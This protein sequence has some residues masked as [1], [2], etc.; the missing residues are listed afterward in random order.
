M[1][2]TRQWS[3]GCLDKLE[4]LY[5][6]KVSKGILKPGV[7][8]PMKR[9]D[10]SKKISKKLISVTELMGMSPTQEDDFWEGLGGQFGKVI[11]KHFPQRRVISIKSKQMESTKWLMA[12]NLL[13]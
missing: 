11:A 2:S 1:K 13:S 10:K 6:D 5:K 8:F 3:L 12:R 7:Q 9:T 4:E